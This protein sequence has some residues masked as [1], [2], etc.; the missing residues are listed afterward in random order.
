MT[1]RNAA[2]AALATIGTLAWTGAALAQSTTTA[3][4]VATCKV[5]GVSVPCDQVGAAAGK[6]L[7][8]GLGILLLFV[9][10]GIA[11]SIFWL[12]MIIHAATHP[13]QHRA[14]WIL[15]MVFTGILGAIIYWIAVKRTFAK[16]SGPTM[17]ATFAASTESS[18]IAPPVSPQLAEYVRTS[19]QQGVADDATRKALIDSGWNASD[20][21]R[22]LR[23]P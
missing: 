9:A 16:A 20:V 19:R 8:M 15:L 23:G 6:A 12:L 4:T 18:P 10:M 21:D 7:G 11:A 3:I 13:V 22:A 2:K 17:P 14:M 1:V 5:N